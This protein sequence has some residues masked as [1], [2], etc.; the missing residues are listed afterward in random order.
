MAAPPARSEISDSYPNPSNAV[1]RAG[2]GKFWDYAINLLGPSGDPVD[3]RSALGVPSSVDAV[4]TGNP[5]APTQ[6]NAENSTRLATTAWVRSA[7]GTIFT[8]LGFAASIGA[9]GYLKL[10]SILGGVVVQW[11]TTVVAV[12]GTGNGA[13]SFPLTFP[14]AVRAVLVSAGDSGSGAYLP[15]SYTTGWPT[16]SGHA[17][18]VINTTTG[19]AFTTGNFRVNWWA[20]GN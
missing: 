17:V 5:I 18:H 2:F 4:L 8:A 7:L 11:G 12:D 19:A 1:A 10:P 14:T 16:T 13:I 3:A 20:I 9:T 6:S 15:Q